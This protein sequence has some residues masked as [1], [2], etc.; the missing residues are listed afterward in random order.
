MSMTSCTS[1]RASLRIFPFSTVISLARS[2]LRAR[3]AS[4]SLRT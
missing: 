1:P 4:P 3:N 2:S